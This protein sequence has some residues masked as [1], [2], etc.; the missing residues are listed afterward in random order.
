MRTGWY[1]SAAGH[2]LLVLLVLFGGFFTRDRFSEVTVAEVSIVT[3]AEYAALTPPETAPETQT[4]A[5]RVLA[6][7]EDEAP[8]APAE[9]EAPEVSEPNPVDIPETPDGSEIDRPQPLPETAVVDDAPEIDM[10]ETEVGGTSL[11]RD[12]VAA[13]APRVAPTP[14]I[15]P[16]PQ[17]E[18]SPDRI[19][20]T[21]PDPEAPAE[22]VVDSQD[23]SAPEEASDRI[24]TEAEETRDKAPAS[25]M[26]PRSRP[27]RPL[28]Q[29]EVPRETT[30][31]DETA[32]A[33]AAA[34][35]EANESD[36]QSA[37]T[38]P[39][40]SGGELDAFRFAIGGCWTIDPG[41][42]S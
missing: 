4:D 24:V 12:V 32:N 33:I 2:F 25:S 7:A 42:R 17:A 20:D 9:D 35:S 13:P 40:L 22:D 6:P 28:R 3:E 15:A 23:P 14:S 21:A 36:S 1:I 30:E 26:R 19:E 39:P 38:G 8:S 29:V 41:A 27:A 34:V 16:P 18:I 10:P 5:P 31:E 11:E 37:P